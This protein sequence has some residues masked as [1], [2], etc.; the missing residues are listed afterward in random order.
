MAK[1]YLMI[2]RDLS[3]CNAQAGRNKR[4]FLVKH[5]GRIALPVY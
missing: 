2:K 1:I 4:L 5:T 3:A